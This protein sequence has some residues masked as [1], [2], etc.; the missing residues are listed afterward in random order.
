MKIDNCYITELHKEKVNLEVVLE[1][2]RNAFK[3]LYKDLRLLEKEFWDIKEERDR[4]TK[5]KNMYSIARNHAESYAFMKANMMLER[6]LD[7]NFRYQD[8][9]DEIDQLWEDEFESKLN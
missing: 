2:E 7:N 9:D 3:K 8:I 6:V 1:Q 4:Q 5:H